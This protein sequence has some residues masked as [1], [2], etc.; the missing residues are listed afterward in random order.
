[1]KWQIV[2]ISGNTDYRD[3]CAGLADVH[4]RNT[5]LQMERALLLSKRCFSGCKKFRFGA[6]PDIVTLEDFNP[7]SLC[8]HLQPRRAWNLCE[9]PIATVFVEAI[10]TCETAR[11]FAILHEQVGLAV[12]VRNRTKNH[13]ELRFSAARRLLRQA[14]SDRDGMRRPDGQFATQNS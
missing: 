8:R 13:S 3:R 10:A 2:S 12:V 14:K 1:M 5:E 6:T 4:A 11:G 9:S 7:P